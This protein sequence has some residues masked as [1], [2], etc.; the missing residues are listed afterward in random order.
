VFRVLGIYNFGCTTYILDA[1]H[2]FLVL[3]FDIDSIITDLSNQ[4]AFLAIFTVPLIMLVVK[5]MASLK[6]ITLN[7]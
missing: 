3:T 5:L 1:V 4:S 2:I 7:G 6:K